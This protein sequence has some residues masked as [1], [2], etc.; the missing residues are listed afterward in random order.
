MTRNCLSSMNTTQ[1]RIYN[2]ASAYIKWVTIDTKKSAL[3]GQCRRRFW[4]NNYLLTANNESRLFVLMTPASI[5]VF[6]RF[7]HSPVWGFQAAFGRLMLWNF[8]I[9][10]RLSKAGWSSPTAS[11]PSVRVMPVKYRPWNSAA[12]W[13]GCCIIAGSGSAA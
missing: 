4:I 3:R 11:I 12:D 7:P 10:F 6:F 2:M 9:R 1:L 8:M 13:K 5:R